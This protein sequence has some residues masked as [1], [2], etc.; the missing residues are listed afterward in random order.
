MKQARRCYK[1]MVC[2]NWVFV[3]VLG[4]QLRHS[5]SSGNWE[6]HGAVWRGLL[7]LSFYGLCTARFSNFARE[8]NILVFI[9]KSCNLKTLTTILFSSRCVRRS[10]YTCLWVNLAC[11]QQFVTSE[12]ENAAL[13]SSSEDKQNK[14]Q[15]WGST[16][17]SKYSFPSQLPPLYFKKGHWVLISVFI[18]HVFVT[19][20][21]PYTFLSLEAKITHE[22]YRMMAKSVIWVR[23]RQG[24]CNLDN[25]EKFHT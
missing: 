25:L 16:R 4:W 13:L 10:S 12:I 21:W 18:S 24:H 6:V 15:T 3:S 1:W 8:T 2:R 23:G 22:I 20:W 14:W 11:R 9:M 19:S 17:N 7:F 5:K